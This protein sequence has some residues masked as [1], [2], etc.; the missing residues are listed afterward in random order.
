MALFAPVA[1][2]ANAGATAFGLNLDK[3]SVELTRECFLLQMRQAKRLFTAQW[4]EAAYH[5]GEAMAQAAQQHAEAQALATA[6]YFQT[7]RIHSEDTKLARDQDTRAYEM[8]WRT[9]AR[10]SLRDELTNQFNRYNTIMLVDAV[11]MGSIMPLV[12]SGEPPQ[13]ITQVHL[14]LYLF[15]LGSCVMLFIVSLW[16]CLV[17]TRRLHEHTAAILERRLFADTE[18]LQKVWQDQIENGLPTDSLV[19]NLLNQAYREWVSRNID[20]LGNA[21]T[22][23]V[24]LFI[25]LTTDCQVL[26]F[27]LFSSH[28]PK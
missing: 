2:A 22:L 9:E 8:G 18:E 10:E 7:E 12:E 4:A 15:S 23:S 1:A 6:Q 27:S 13:G 21:G 28:A 19:L 11:C 17:V 14:A 16:I 20:P 26:L 5:H 3:Q 25:V 24:L